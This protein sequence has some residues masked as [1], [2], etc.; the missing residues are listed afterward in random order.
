MPYMRV[1]TI[2]IAIVVSLC[3]AKFSAYGQ[4]PS[5]NLIVDPGFET[6]PVLDGWVLQ[7]EARG[8]G[9]GVSSVLGI[10]SGR[11]SLGLLPNNQN[12]S[13]VGQPSFG[14]TKLLKVQ[15]HVGQPLYFSGWLKV[16]PGA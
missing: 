11:A 15:G 2:F 6:N 10:H 12:V 5:P 1:L 14:V 13:G 7:P 16:D 9:I 4:D 8:R 3:F